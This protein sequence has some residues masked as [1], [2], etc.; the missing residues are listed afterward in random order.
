MELVVVR[1][2]AEERPSCVAALAGV[3]VNGTD[4]L[5]KGLGAY[6]VDDA[7]GEGQPALPYA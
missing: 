7:N 6:L 1:L 2:V 4:V 5:M 3:R